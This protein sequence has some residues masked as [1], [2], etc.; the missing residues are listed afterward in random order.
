MKRFNL[1]FLFLGMC[2][3]IFM[4]NCS[5]PASESD[6]ADE[7]EE[8]TI[9]S[10][11]DAVADNQLTE[12]EQADGWRLLFDGNTADQWKIYNTDTL[13]GWQIKDGELIALG[14]GGLNGH[15]ADIIT[16]EQFENFEMKVDWKVSEGGNSG[17]FF[18]VLEGDQYGAVYETGPE[19]Q[20][21]DDAGYGDRIKDTQMSGAN[22]DMHPPSKMA[23]HPAGTYN[24]TMI[25]VE[26]GH[27]QHWLNGEL[28]VAYD[29]WTDEWEELKANSK[30]KDHPNYG[31][32][33]KGHIA[34]QDHGK[35]IWFKNI[36]IRT[37]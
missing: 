37:L 3:S 27:V 9:T 29:L 15:G 4:L 2:L 12:A 16:R 10:E 33:K 36:K 25:K 28:V 7:N 30:W 1:S 5:S 11:N 35:K 22:Y 13:V 24:E 34:L 19:Y 14:E 23:V 18:G 32:A 17:L 31:M 20:L 6:A 8:M 21:I 26:N